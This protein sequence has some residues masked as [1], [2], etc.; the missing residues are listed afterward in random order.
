MCYDCFSDGTSQW[1]D[2]SV[3]SHKVN[4]GSKRQRMNVTLAN[5][6][7]VAVRKF[8]TLLNNVKLSAVFV[9]V[10]MNNAVVNIKLQ[11]QAGSRADSGPSRVTR[12]DVTLS[13]RMK[14]LLTCWRHDAGCRSVCESSSD[15]GHVR[16]V[17]ADWPTHVYKAS[18]IT[19]A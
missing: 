13:H 16:H 18:C 17:R 3:I 4:G 11:R 7:A 15:S 1:W 10:A 14:P 9:S 8:W 6:S 12:R 5:W 19:N 2:I